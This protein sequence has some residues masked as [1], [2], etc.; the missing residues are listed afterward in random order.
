MSRE[1]GR[2]TNLLSGGNTGSRGLRVQ[3]AVSDLVL[4]PVTRMRGML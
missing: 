2:G 4:P 3:A 1:G